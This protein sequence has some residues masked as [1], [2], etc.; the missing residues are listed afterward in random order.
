MKKVVSLFMALIMAL[1]L[2]PV[3]AVS[4]AEKTTV[5]LNVADGKIRICPTY[6]EING[7]VT[8]CDASQTAYVL[9]GNRDSAND[10]III[11][12]TSDTAP[13]V[14]YDVTFDNLALSPANWAS[15]FRIGGSSD[16]TKDNITVNLTIKG[17]CSLMGY[18]HPGLGG[19]ATINIVSIDNGY[20][21]VSAK[22]EQSNQAISDD[23]VI[24][25]LTG[26][27]AV[28]VGDVYNSPF[29]S[30]R[31]RKPLVISS[32]YSNMHVS[33]PVLSAVE[34]Q[35][36]ADLKP[37]CDETGLSG[38]VTWLH[39]EE[40]VGEASEE[41]KRFTAIFVP[42]DMINYGIVMI[43]VSVLVSAKAPEPVTAPAKAKIVK[44][45]KGKKRF[46]VKWNKVSGADG[47]IIRYSLKKNMKKAK[48]VN[49]KNGAAVKKT[50][51]KLKAG[52]KYYVK[53]C[54]YKKNGKK[55]LK[56]KWSAKK[57]VKVK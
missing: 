30:A 11:A 18:N 57:S 22:Y 15:I 46:T 37:V 42:D 49:V 53:V 52:K 41:A 17:N 24:K 12:N 4:A 51:K 43:N 25:D 9:T 40:S 36:L 6:Y 13:M 26:C 47:Y 20:L 14:T 5:T 21:Y 8:S 19:N 54:A 48:T 29:E 44:L 34:G 27:A 45:T 3:T 31:A 1:A 55:V 38:T 56:G 50:V 23:I 28:T 35:T 2:L 39:P 33:V 7:T 32:S 16:G 10:H